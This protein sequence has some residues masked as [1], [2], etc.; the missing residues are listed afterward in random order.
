[1][2]CLKSR[3]LAEKSTILAYQQRPPADEALRFNLGFTDWPF[4]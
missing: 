3:F 1:M 4:G 2:S